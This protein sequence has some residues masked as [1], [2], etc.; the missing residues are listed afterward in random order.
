M[1]SRTV[2]HGSGEAGDA[3]MRINEANPCRHLSTTMQIVEKKALPLYRMKLESLELECGSVPTFSLAAAILLVFPHVPGSLVSLRLTSLPCIAQLLLK[4]IAR[5]C[6]NL[7]ELQL[8]VVERLSTDC[9]W[10]CFEELSSCVTH[11]PV[12]SDAAAGDL[13]VGDWPPLNP[14]NT[15][16]VVPLGMLCSV[17][18]A[19]GESEMHLYR[20]IPLFSD[21]LEGTHRQPL[22]GTRG[23]A[24]HPVHFRRFV[25]RPPNAR[26]RWPGGTSTCIFI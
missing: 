10:A 9:C 17:P 13:A 14:R 24:A 18:P 7:R 4:E 19:S 2:V 26:S 8:S 20:G 22:A 23:L 16:I 25:L 5:R 15:L 12:G 11:S 3:Y 6:T 21:H 1:T